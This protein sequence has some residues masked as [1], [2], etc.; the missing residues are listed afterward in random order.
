MYM[1][2]YIYIYIYIAARA[3]APEHCPRVM[4]G[5]WSTGLLDYLRPST[6]IM[7]M[8]MIIILIIN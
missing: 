1:H 2:I 5:S 4:R 7:I 6:R 3:R 8:I